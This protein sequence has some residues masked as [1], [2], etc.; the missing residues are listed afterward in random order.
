[1]S[2]QETGPVSLQKLIQGGRHTQPERAWILGAELGHHLLGRYVSIRHPAHRSHVVLRHAILNLK[3]D[4]S[5]QKVAN[6]RCGL[7]GANQR[8]R[9]DPRDVTR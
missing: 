2:D 3:L 4:T 7:I 5:I 6:D 1:M 9:D 8:R